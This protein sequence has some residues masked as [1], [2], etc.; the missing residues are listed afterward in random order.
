M[1]I[2]VVPVVGSPRFL[3]LLWFPG[4]LLTSEWEVMTLVVPVLFT[5][6]LRQYHRPSTMIAHRP[7]QLRT[8]WMEKRLE[9]TFL[10]RRK[11]REIVVIYGIVLKISYIFFQGATTSSPPFTC[12]R[13][14]LDVWFVYT[15]NASGILTIDTCSTDTT[16][17]SIDLNLTI[18]VWLCKLIHLEICILVKK[19]TSWYCAR[20]LF[21][22]M[23]II[24]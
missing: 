12:G 24:E 15:A 2:R 18:L 3:S 4:T 17:K 10:Q 22:N 1:M 5:S 23:W 11:S 8:T 16:C 9:W 14:G 13:G 19:Y 21:R 20:G 7:L 6:E